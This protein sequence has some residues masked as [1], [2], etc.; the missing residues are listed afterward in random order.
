MP[1]GDDKTISITQFA[2]QIETLGTKLASYCNSIADVDFGN[3]NSSADA[4]KKIAEAL[5]GMGDVSSTAAKTFADSVNALA[6]ADIKGFVS[7][8]E[9]VDTSKLSSVGKD[10][11]TGIA[12]GIKGGAASITSAIKS[13]MSSAANSAKGS[14]SSFKT[15]GSSFSKAL[16]SGIKSG[17]SGAKTAARSMAKSAASS[18]KARSSSF[19]SAGLS[20]AEGFASGIAAGQSQAIAAAVNMAAAAYAAAKKK[21]DVNSPSKLFRRMAIC[22]P[23]GFAQGIVRGTKYVIAASEKMA[24]TSIDTTENALNKIASLNLDSINTDPTIRP[25]VDLSN[26][27]AGADKIASM[28]NLNPSVGLAANLGAI[29]SAMNSRNQNDSNQDVINALRDVKRAIT[30]SAKPTYNING[31]TYDDG[32]NVSNAVSDLVRAVKI[33]GRV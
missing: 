26:V 8:F 33:E 9:G 28:L 12:S 17:A 32:S 25:V 2:G 27:S 23:E 3:V 21:L 14:T 15:V 5:K 20:C 29:N 30:K 1:S 22:V 16:A 4:I 24:N 13:V 11:M 18:A 6:G 7:T 19:R 31:I 10:M